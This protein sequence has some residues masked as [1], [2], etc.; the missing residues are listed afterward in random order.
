[1]LWLDKHKPELK[2]IP[3]QI[4]LK[5]DR[6]NVFGDKAMGIF[7]HFEEMTAF[8]PG[9]HYPDKKKMVLNT[10]HH[11]KIGTEVICEAAFD[12]NGCFCAVDIL[13]KVEDGYE[14]FE[15]KNS[16][17]VRREHIEDAGYQRYV[18][19]KCGVNLVG[20]N[21]IF[22]N[23]DEDCPFE[24]VDVW[25][26]TAEYARIVEENIDRLSEI[27]NISS[28]IMTEPGEQCTTPHECWYRRHCGCLPEAEE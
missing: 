7:G 21:I 10:K 6:G 19:E 9:T 23:G 15:V 12:Y 17:E 27:R 11:M 24:E 14:M 13:L 3:E 18:L 5:L 2:D 28:E 1:M 22:N 16:P 4:Q 20:V 26:E 25:D 8:I